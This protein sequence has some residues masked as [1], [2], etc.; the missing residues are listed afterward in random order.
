VCTI[1]IRLSRILDP[2]RAGWADRPI[3]P[4][5]ELG[6]R[7][8]ELPNALEADAARLEP[9]DEQEGVDDVRLAAAVGPH[10]R[11]E[12][13]RGPKK[14]YH[15]AHREGRRGHPN[16]PFSTIVALPSFNCCPPPPKIKRSTRK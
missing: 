4:P 14:P 7:V 9:E 12:E 3:R 10:H 13:L 11:R 6:G 2:E 15:R 8:D 16:L 5:R 1:V